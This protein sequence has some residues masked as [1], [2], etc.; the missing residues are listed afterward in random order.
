MRLDLMLV[1]RGLAPTRQKAQA[2]I[3]AGA[4]LVDEHPVEKAGA[5]VKPEADIRIR[6]NP[7]P[8]VS[9]G[10]LKLA[11]ALQAFSIAPAGLVAL[12]VGIST[13]GFT[14]CLL[15]A[16]VAKVFGV[17][18]GRGQVAWKLRQ[19][20]RVVLF[21][22]TNFRSFEPASLPSPVDLAVI[23]VSFISLTLIL[24]TVHR[25]LKP[26]AVALPL[27]KPQFEVGRGEVGRK[28]VVRDEAKR[29]AAVDKIATFAADNGF[30]VLSRT[31]SPVPGPEGNI[32]YF[33]HLRRS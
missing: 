3:M 25:C 17:D 2:M 12:D 11:H 7:L 30:A 21:E 27:V 10:G 4:V 18:V 22:G 23:D 26:N 14:D 28:G 15:Q 31:E 9:R 5:D 6:G 19:D 13:G 24:P 1:E 32:E 33:L 29:F 20:P 8:F 16:G